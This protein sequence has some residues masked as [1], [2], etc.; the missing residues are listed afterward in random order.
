[1]TDQ[2]KIELPLLPRADFSYSTEAMERYGH[3]AVLADRKH[4]A[5]QAK[6]KVHSKWIEL[7]P[8]GGWTTIPGLASYQNTNMMLNICWTDDGHVWINNERNRE[9]A[10]R[11][12]YYSASDEDGLAVK[13]FEAVADAL[14]GGV[15]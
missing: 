6:P 8:D 15:R 4:R 2:D 5:E 14:D 9:L 10:K 1:M 13:D 7:F 12:R 11:M 3:A